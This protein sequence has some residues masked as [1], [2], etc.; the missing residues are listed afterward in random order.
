MM[1]CCS[2]ISKLKFVEDRNAY[3]KHLEEKLEHAT[4]S[5][6]DIQCL[7]NQVEQLRSQLQAVENRSPGGVRMDDVPEARAVA[8]AGSPGSK[9]EIEILKD[10]LAR[11]EEKVDKKRPGIRFPNPSIDEV[12]DR[13]DEVESASCRLADDCLGAVESVN[14]KLESLEARLSGK[15]Q[16]ELGEITRE[17]QDR[18]TEGIEKIALVLRKLVAVQKSNVISQKAPNYPRDHRKRLIEELQEEIDFLQRA[19]Y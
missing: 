13:L 1:V 3:I 5:A 7:S 18:L 2:D 11:L 17:L 6:L 12:W 10:R 9:I 15:L 16:T 8:S 4:S 19:G 14:S